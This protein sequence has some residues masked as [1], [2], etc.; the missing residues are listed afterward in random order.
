MEGYLDRLKFYFKVTD[1]STLIHSN[2]EVLAAKQRLK[3]VG[4]SSKAR[5]EYIVNAAT[6]AATNELIPR[7]FR[8][9][10]ISMVNIPI[11]F[12]MLACPPTHLAPSLFLHFVNQ[13]YNTACNYYN[14]SVKEQS[15]EQTAIAYGLAVSSACLVAGGM[16]VWWRKAPPSLKRLGVLV[17]CLATSF[18]NISNIGFTRS[19]EIRNGTQVYDKD[20]NEQGLLFCWE[21]TCPFSS[22]YSV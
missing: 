21:Y 20:G 14:R 9:S 13:S 12:G 10:A 11:V 6:N 19:S 2:A 17:P 5:D 7:A 8:V 15:M 1:P 3:D 16:G 22:V 4:S 18:A